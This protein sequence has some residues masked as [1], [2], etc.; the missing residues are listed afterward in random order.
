[1]KKV[2][3]IVAAFFAVCS[4]NAFAFT[5]ENEEAEPVAVEVSAPEASFTSLAF[6]PG[7]EYWAIDPQAVRTG[8]KYKQLKDLYNPR[9]YAPESGDPYSTL[10]CLWNLLIPGLGQMTMGEVGRGFGWFASVCGTSIVGGAI[11]GAMLGNSVKI[12]SYGDI[13][14]V[15]AGLAAGGYAVLVISSLGATALEIISIVDA[16]K[17]AKVKNLYARDINAMYGVDVKMQPYVVAMKTPQGLQP[18]AGLT[19]AVN[20]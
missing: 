20:F 15:N 2:V 11:G 10:R 14:E 18:A 8:M 6:A 4:L 12:D 9:D 19:L 7:A 5:P 1:M 3:A 17:V 16:V 13:T